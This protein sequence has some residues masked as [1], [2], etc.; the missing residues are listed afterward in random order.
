MKLIEG[1]KIFS[2][3]GFLLQRDYVYKY[4]FTFMFVFVDDR[5]VLCDEA[6]EH[7]VVYFCQKLLFDFMEWE[8]YF[9]E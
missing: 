1:C 3:Q 5:Y 9:W 8:I 6:L 7:Y 2:G 4:L